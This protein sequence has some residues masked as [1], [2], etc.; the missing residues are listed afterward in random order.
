MFAH[1]GKIDERSIDRGMKSGG[2]WSSR[3]KLL[4]SA[5]SIIMR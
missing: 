3:R 5:S 1:T 2:T 4:S